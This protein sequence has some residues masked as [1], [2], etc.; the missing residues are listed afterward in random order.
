MRGTCDTRCI[1][2]G[3]AAASCVPDLF[4]ETG[5]QSV[6][7]SQPASTPRA[8]HRAWLTASR[9]PAPRRSAAQPRTARRRPSSFP[10]VDRRSGVRTSGTPPRTR[11]APTSYLV[12]RPDGNLDGRLPPS[13]PVRRRPARST[14]GGGLAP[15]LLTH[16]DDVADAAAVGRAY[17][18]R[19]SATDRR[20]RSRPRPYAT[21]V[22]D[23]APTPGTVGA[24]DHGDPGPGPHPRLGRLPRRR[25]LAGHGRLARLEL[26]HARTSSPSG[27]PAGT[28]WSELDHLARPAGRRSP[29]S[30]GSSR[31]H[32][33]RVAPRSRRRRPAASRP[34]S[35]GCRRP[36]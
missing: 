23:E 34:S 31:A 13:S 20:R 3:D 29:P 17:G 8:E 6:V 36:T 18:A 30:S 10:L 22:L 5:N 35:R 14:P 16:R 1:D 9:L 2:C 24:E 26:P 4:D 21:D 15:V 11:S 33:P 7:Q 12:E 19:V 32:G 28:A 25:P 27:A